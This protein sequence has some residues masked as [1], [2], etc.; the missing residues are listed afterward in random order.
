MARFLT[1]TQD[2]M[3]GRGRR[4]QAYKR[5][6]K[7]GPVSL[8]VVTIVLITIFSFLFIVLANSTSVQSVNYGQLQNKVSELHEKNH[9]LELEAAELR[10][11]KKL[12]KFS[13]GLNMVSAQNPV[14]LE[15]VGRA[16]ASR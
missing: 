10:S 3:L 16:V 6:F 15:E 9:Q 7:T 13:N 8:T 1:L 11:L 12:E 5:S 14:Y 2:N 4:R